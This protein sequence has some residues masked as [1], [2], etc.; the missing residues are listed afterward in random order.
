MNPFP[1]LKVFDILGSSPIGV[2]AH[3]PLSHQF[4][5]CCFV[6]QKQ[7]GLMK[8]YHL[9]AKAT[10]A[11]HHFRLTRIL[12]LS[13]SQV[14]HIFHHLSR[15]FAFHS[16]CQH[17]M[18]LVP[19]HSLVWGSLDQLL[20]CNFWYWILICSRALIQKRSFRWITL[21]HF[22]SCQWQ[23]SLHSSLSMPP[24]QSF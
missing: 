2:C 5:C 18:I 3:Q 12:R 23:Q 24:I 10:G 22:W 6:Y 15:Q 16:Y 13:H 7:I 14:L 21:A 17:S 11:L 19:P 9:I 8:S 20:F 1:K 4:A